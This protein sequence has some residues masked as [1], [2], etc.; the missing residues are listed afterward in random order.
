MSVWHRLT[1][2][3]DAAHLLFPALLSSR[4]LIPPPWADES[5]TINLPA[6]KPG[7]AHPR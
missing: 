6:S 3:A 4:L 5:G 7:P 1:I 2:S